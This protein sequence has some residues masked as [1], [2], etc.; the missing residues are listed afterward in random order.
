MSISLRELAWRWNS[1]IIR[2]NE[3]VW[4]FAFAA[5]LCEAFMLTRSRSHQCLLLCGANSWAVWCQ[6]PIQTKWSR[7]DPVILFGI[8]LGIKQTR[9]TTCP[10]LLCPITPFFHFVASCDDE[11]LKPSLTSRRYRFCVARSAGRSICNSQWNA[12]IHVSAVLMPVIK[13]Q[14]K[15]YSKCHP[16]DV[17]LRLGRPLSPRSHGGIHFLPLLEWSHFP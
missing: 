17:Q 1:F 5:V 2:Q 15:G 9:R 14:G 3:R 6:K 13:S 16:A 8:S 7:L 4:M 11:S 10:P 12:V